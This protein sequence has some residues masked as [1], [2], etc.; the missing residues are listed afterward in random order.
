MKTEHK[1][2]DNKIDR[3]TK[4]ELKKKKLL[5]KLSNEIIY[6]NGKANH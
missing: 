2:F 1:K 6:K 5:Q 4:D 3:K